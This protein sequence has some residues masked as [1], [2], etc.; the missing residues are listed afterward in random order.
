MRRNPRDGTTRRRHLHGH[1][2]HAPGERGGVRHPPFFWL[3]WQHFPGTP[4]CMKSPPTGDGVTAV[5]SRLGRLTPA[6]V[7]GGGAVT[8]SA[9][10]GRTPEMAPTIRGLPSA[11]CSPRTPLSEPELPYGRQRNEEPVHGFP[12]GGARASRSGPDPPP[13]RGSSRVRAGRRREFTPLSASCGYGG[14]GGRGGPQISRTPL[15]EPELPHWEGRGHQGLHPCFRFLGT[16]DRSGPDP[17]KIRGLARVRAGHRRDGTSLSVTH[18]G[19]P[20]GPG[21]GRL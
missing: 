9:R 15:T 7:P 18:R 19:G 12:H 16:G 14:G 13:I 4:V 10:P 6:P 5:A 11:S 2:P 3:V 21:G 1:S 20:G 17:P 8:V